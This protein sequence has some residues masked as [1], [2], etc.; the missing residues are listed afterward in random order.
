M[1]GTFSIR[2]FPV[3]QVF[4]RLTTLNKTQNQRQLCDTILDKQL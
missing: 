1:K 2:M 4:R 3:F